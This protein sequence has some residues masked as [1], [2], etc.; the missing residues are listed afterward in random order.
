MKVLEFKSTDGRSTI[1]WRIW[2]AKGEPKAVLQIIH[3]MSDHISRYDAFASWL[4]ENGVTV[5]GDDHI[6]HGMSSDPSEYGYFGEKDGHKRLVDDEEELRLIVRAKFPE[7]PYFMLGHS[8]GSFMLRTWLAIYGEKSDIA[9]AIIM[10]TCGPNKLLSAG[11]LLTNILKIVK[12]A[13]SKSKLLTTMALGPY[14]KPFK[15]EPSI[16]SWLS[17]VPEVAVDYDADPMA[18][19]PFTIGGYRDMFALIEFV[20]A[21]SWYGMVPKGIPLF[22]CS[23]R[24]DPVGDFGRGPEFTFGKLK[25]AGCSVELKLY[26]GMRHEILGETGKDFVWKDMLEFIESDSEMRING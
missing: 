10:G 23:G 15:G 7:L 5:V 9:G 18:G 4:S 13:K 22:I 19:F 12:G 14:R 8:M 20:T 16:N 6:G 3:G 21:D 25:D 26:D 1:K 2:E 24:N 11:I 17:T